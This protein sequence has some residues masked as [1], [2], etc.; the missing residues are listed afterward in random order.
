MSYQI[1]GSRLTYIIFAVLNVAFIPMIYFFYPRGQRYEPHWSP[2]LG[3]LADELF[4][5]TD[6]REVTLTFEQ[7][8]LLFSGPKVLL[9]IS[10]EELPSMQEAEIHN[11]AVERR[12]D[13]D[14][15]KLNVLHIEDVWLS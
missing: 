1:S 13:V 3:F 2:S 11:A 4:I 9:D 7:I 6:K 8:D 12:I 10:N 14:E 15:T 5:F